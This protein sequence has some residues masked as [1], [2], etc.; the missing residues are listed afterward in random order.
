MKSTILNSISPIDNLLESDEVYTLTFPSINNSSVINSN[1]SWSIT[2]STNTVNSLSNIAP[3]D[4]WVG[5]SSLIDRLE[6]IEK[7]IAE[8]EKNSNL[9]LRYPDLKKIGDEYSKLKS[10]LMEKEK[11]LEILKR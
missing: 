11:V 8:V 6:S 10:E 1:I 4:I 9:E 2:N 5:G 3:G 7:R